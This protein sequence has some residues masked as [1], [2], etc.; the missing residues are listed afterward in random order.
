M[1]KTRIIGLA[2]LFI[3]IIIQFTL[4]ND[5][6]DFI[7]GLSVGGGIGLLFSGKKPKVL[8]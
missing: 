2:I 5:T 7:S 3:G 1:N 8:D 4:E 6:A